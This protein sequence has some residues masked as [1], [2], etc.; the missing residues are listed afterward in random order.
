L[1]LPEPEKK[2]TIT[3]AFTW[4]EKEKSFPYIYDGIVKPKKRKRSTGLG[5][6]DEGGIRLGL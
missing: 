1:K 4:P 5:F 6:R 3:L 2:E